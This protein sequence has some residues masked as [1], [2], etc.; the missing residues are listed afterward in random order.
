M[1]DKKRLTP[2]NEIVFP[3]EEVA[4]AENEAWLDCHSIVNVLNVL[5]MQLDLLSL[6]FD[7]LDHVQTTHAKIQDISSKIHQEKEEVGEAIEDCVKFDE[8]LRTLIEYLSSSEDED[9][10]SFGPVFEEISVRLQSCAKE[11]L[12]RFLHPNAWIRLTPNEIREQIQSFY[13]AVAKNS[14]RKYGFVY[15]DS[16]R[17]PNIYRVH[18]RLEP[19]QRGFFEMPPVMLDTLRDLAANARKYTPPGGDIE[20]ALQVIDKQISLIVEDNGM[21]IPKEEITKVV[22]FGFRA[23]NTEHIRTMGGGFGLTKALS[24]SS[25]YKG[26]MKIASAIGEGTRITIEIPIASNESR[27]PISAV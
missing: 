21:G 15:D 16:H 10:Q 12:A 27:L 9:I 3:W 26:I 7:S 24:V 19:N 17:D 20:I 23:S 6:E 22:K 13:T 25:R 1:T 18:L 8:E 2:W 14:R 11:L 4:N 5:A